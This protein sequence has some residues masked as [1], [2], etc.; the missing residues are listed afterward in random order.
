[1]PEREHGVRRLPGVD[2]TVVRGAP[3][4]R[5]AEVADL[6]RQD[7]R[8]DDVLD[9]GV[10]QV[11][12]DVGEHA[13]VTGAGRGASGSMWSRLSSA[14]GVVATV[15]M[16]GPEAAQRRE[17]ARRPRPRS[18]SQIASTTTKERPRTGSGISGIGGSW[19]MRPTE[20]ISSGRS[21]V[22]A[23]HTLRISAARSTGNQ[24]T[25]A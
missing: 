13:A 2:R 1:M 10:D 24:R 22:Q 18:P 6:G 5:A 17:Q 20:V 21:S 23:R 8:A 4:D 9:E 7:R 25:P 19:R 11:A 16:V 12:V 15:S 14:I 3:R